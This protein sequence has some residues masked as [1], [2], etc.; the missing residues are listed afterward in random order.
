MSKA[1]DLIEKMSTTSFYDVKITEELLINDDLRDLA[2]KKASKAKDG[3]MKYGKDIYH[4]KFDQKDWVYRVFKNKE[5]EEYTNFNCKTLS[6][7][8][9]WL[10]DYLE[11]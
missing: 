4:L 3:K 6:V 11:N 7:A 5:L 9:K 1:K 8:K 2:R 10:I